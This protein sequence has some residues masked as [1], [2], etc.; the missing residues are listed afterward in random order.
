MFCLFLF[1]GI[2]FAFCV[3]F[4]L[5]VHICSLDVL[6]RVPKDESHF[7]RTQKAEFDDD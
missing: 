6:L 7:R 3:L 4:N 2:L 1:S 5:L